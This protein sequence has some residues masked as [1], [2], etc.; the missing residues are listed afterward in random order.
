MPLSSEAPGARKR[1]AKFSSTALLRT[2]LSLKP[3]EGHLANPHL[4][5]DH[6][7]RQPFM[8]LDSHQ[9]FWR[10]SPTEHTWMTDQMRLSS[11]IFSLRI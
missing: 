9:H 1:W 4:L 11:K 5:V 7:R 8:R 10:Y 6:F 3:H 2:S